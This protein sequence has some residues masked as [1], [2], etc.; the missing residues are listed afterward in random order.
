MLAK[1]FCLVSAEPDCSILSS[2]SDSGSISVQNKDAI[3]SLVSE[4][5]V[6][7]SGGMLNANSNITLAEFL[8]VLYRVAENYTSVSSFESGI[9]GGSV[10]RGDGTINYI[11]TDNIWFGCDTGSIFLSSVSADTIT[12]RSHKLSSF[13]LSN[14][15]IKRLVFALG[16]GSAAIG[17]GSGSKIGTV[18]LES[19]KSADIGPE[20]GVVE[21]TGSGINVSISG[22]HDYLIITGNENII[23]LSPNASVTRLKIS[24]SGN[25]VAPKDDFS[26][27]TISCTEIELYGS[28]NTVSV[29][30]PSSVSAK[31]TVGGDGNKI[32]SKFG[33][34]SSLRVTGTKC[35][36]NASIFSDIPVIEVT[37]S[38]NL[39]YIAYK[40]NTAE[41]AQ[42]AEC[43][44]GSASIS[45]NSNWITISCGSISS[46]SISGNYNTLKKTGTGSIGSF[47]MPGSQN[48]IALQGSGELVSA[49][50]SGGDNH[51]PL[52]GTAGTITIDGRGN[53]LDGGGRISSLIL[54]AYGCTV[55][56]PASNVTDNINRAE[57][58]RVLKLV[59]LGYKGN[60]TLK[61]A[62]EHDYKDFEKEIWVNAKGYSSSTDYLIWVNLSMQRV[63]IFRGSEG[64]WKLC[65]SCIV[66]TGAPGSGTPVGVWRTTY[67][68]WAGWTTSTYTVKPVVGFKQNTGY[69]FHS[70]LYYPGTT[71]LSDASIG[72]PVSHGCVRMYDADIK[73][74]YDN[75]P[76]GTTVVVY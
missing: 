72:Y 6:L 44:I 16:E 25:S 40:E 32:L 19:C 15:N 64:N 76:L 3:A 56:I 27:N 65:H 11:A 5:L 26:S 41:I 63:N 29:G 70:R 43:K 38:E 67:K 52:N 21:I 73:Y 35:S 42:N 53:T 45:G 39:V 20:A 51:V 58:E 57:T 60:F 23:T 7:G 74:I 62:Q 37:G 50:I 71:T 33:S 31:I 48:A 68:T 55:N 54:N 22:N 59:T 69:A 46:V 28:S 30:T 14:S 17:T 13:S 2:F 47:D 18:R 49:K 34:I 75:I 4:K 12:L 8:T 61:W 36:I 66:G 24:G 9:S 1:A 10:I